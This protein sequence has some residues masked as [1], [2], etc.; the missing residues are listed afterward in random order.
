[1]D[2]KNG[3]PTP[4]EINL[5]ETH[6]Y[7][8]QAFDVRSPMKPLHTN[9]LKRTRSEIRRRICAMPVSRQQV[10]QM[11][12]VIAELRRENALLTYMLSIR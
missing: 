4:F 12:K 7:P 11:Q 10:R 2:K 5:P 3:Y 8:P 1:M 9:P 6:H